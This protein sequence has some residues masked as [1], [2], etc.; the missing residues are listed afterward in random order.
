MRGRVCARATRKE[1]RINWMNGRENTVVKCVDAGW[2]VVAERLVND[3]FLF[4]KRIRGC[5][6]GGKRRNVEAA[7]PASA[8]K[9]GENYFRSLSCGETGAL[10][11][12]FQLRPLTSAQM[13]PVGRI[14][15]VVPLEI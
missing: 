1:T 6:F 4:G 2:T 9:A 5:Y 3:R 11:R 15:L 12:S 13:W 8:K 14:F 10:S 7:R